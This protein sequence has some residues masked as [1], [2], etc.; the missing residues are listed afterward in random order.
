MDALRNGHD[1][2]GRPAGATPRSKIAIIIGAGPAGLTAAYE[3]LTR[4][5]IKPVILERSDAMGGLARTV[6]YKGNRIDIGG[7]RFFSKSDRVMQWWMNQ[8][9]FE[10]NG[11]GPQKISYHGM[12]RAINGNHVDGAVDTCES[13]QV[14][15]VRK[16]KSRIYF[17]RQFFDYPISLTG[18]T[19]GKLG[20]IRTLRIACSYM[21]SAIFP[22]KSAQ[23]LEQF[24]VNRFGRELYE[25]FFKSYTEK[26]WGVPCDEIS[27]EWGQQRIKGLS[28][29]KSVKHFLTR[30]LRKPSGVAQRD[31][32]TSL[33]EQFLYPT[34]GPGQMWEGVAEQIVKMGGE[35]ITN[36]EVAGVQCCANTVV[37]LKAIKDGRTQE[38]AGDYFFSTMAIKE[39]IRAMD[40]PIPNNVREVSEGLLY[41]DFITVGLLV[42]KLKV[43]N[44]NKKLI[45]DNWIYIQEPDVLAG[46]LQIFNNWS[47]SMVANQDHVWMGVEYFC[48]ETDDLWK[49]SD[50]DMAALAGEELDKIGILDK[51]DILDSMVIRVPKTYP[52]YFGTFNRF[53]EIRKFVDGFENLFLIG[54]NG[55]HRYN[56]Q[57]H[58]MLT[59]MMAV[60]NISAGITEKANLWEVNTEMEYHEAAK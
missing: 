1:L 35:I 17:L 28:I 46:R 34:L 56:N 57:D 2:G 5:N 13:D 52:A 19:L 14:M 29:A 8:M 53:E 54:R 4:T 12:S 41:R 36:C 23:N 18:D 30:R 51:A 26:I 25:T 50:T 32:D 47:P 10:Q 37:S 59:A 22:I 9:P 27:A 7:H 48:Y 21:K 58:S 24:F 11:S 45:E 15:L 33:I 55:M 38:F 43:Q 3:L 16:R 44:R 40:A 31:V 39:L 20:F 60:D 42:K 6:R 49:K